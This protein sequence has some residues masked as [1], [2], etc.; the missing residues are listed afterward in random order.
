[1]I[2][3]YHARTWNISVD[4]SQRSISLP[5]D[6][7]MLVVI[8]ATFLLE[9]A[10]HYIIESEMIAAAT[11]IVPFMAAAIWTMFIG[12]S[13]G[14]NLNLAIRYAL[15]PPQKIGE[16]LPT[17]RGRCFVQQTPV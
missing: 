16:D 11:P 9:F 8:L 14:R 2:D 10:L 5:R 7:M 1:M 3:R 12:M 4:H 13:V 6:G 17:Q 15:S